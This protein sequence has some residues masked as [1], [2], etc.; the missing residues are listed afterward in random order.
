MKRLFALCTVAVVGALAACGGCD[1]DSAKNS[2]DPNSGTSNNGKP[3][4]ST[5]TSGNSTSTGNPGTTG[6]TNNNNNGGNGF[7]DQTREEFC[8]GSGPPIIVGDLGQGRQALCTG[9]IAQV[10]F[11]YGLCVCQ[12]FEVGNT[13]RS[14]SF[15][16]ARGTS[17]ERGG[18]V[19][20]NGNLTVGNSARVGG[21]LWVA[22][23]EGIEALNTIQVNH[24]LYA[25]G[26]VTAN[27]QIIVE[28][29]AAVAGDVSANVVTID[30]TLTQPAA[31]TVDAN[32]TNIGATVDGAVTI[33]DPCDCTNIFDIAAFAANHKVHNHNADIG[34]DPAA[35]VNAGTGAEIDLPCGIFYLDGATVTNTITFNVTGRTA[36]FIGGDLGATNTIR[37]VLADG[38][39]F[40]LFVEGNVEVGNSLTLGS[41]RQPAAARMYV[42]GTSVN[43]GNGG[44][45]AGNMYAPRAVVTVGNSVEVFGSMFV[46]EFDGGNSFIVHYDS[47][48]LTAGDTCEDTGGGDGGNTPGPGGD[49]GDMCGDC[50]DCGNQACNDGEC[51]TCRSDADC[52]S[53]LVCFQGECILVVL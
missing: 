53:P 7:I 9:D 44:R 19:G 48:I 43:L 20:V 38:A 36:L 24:Y 14:D 23:D 52:C 35:L 51:G 28:E 27:T 50:T 8:A 5:S 1:D 13:L 18:A 4:N 11:R 39:E 10:T 22:G 33:A 16:S 21:T 2:G 49:P 31:S 12:D 45:F 3:N 47:A 29:D 40:D 34:L 17:D 26:D 42:G 32:N 15:N 37:A 30:G 6:T 25:N 46:G 41:E